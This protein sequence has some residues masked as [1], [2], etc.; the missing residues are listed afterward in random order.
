MKAM[1]IKMRESVNSPASDETIALRPNLRPLSAIFILL[2]T[3][4]L[5]VDPTRNA[6]SEAAATRGAMLNIKSKWG[7]PSQNEAAG[8]QTTSWPASIT[9]KFMANPI[10]MTRRALR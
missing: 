4:E 5:R 9:K 6:N 8:S 1:G 10:Q 7:A 2:S 3:K